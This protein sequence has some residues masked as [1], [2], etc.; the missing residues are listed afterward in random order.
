MQQSRSSVPAILGPGDHIWQHKLTQD[1]PGDHIWQ[2]KLT[3]DG[4]DDHIWDDSTSGTVL[5]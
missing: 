3:Q 1:G 2:H 5:P 4:P